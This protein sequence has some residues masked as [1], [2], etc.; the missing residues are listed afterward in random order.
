VARP[1]FSSRKSIFDP[2][3][4]PLTVEGAA[5]SLIGTSAFQ[6]LW[7]IRQTGF[8]HLV[9]PG[10]NH[11]RLEHSLGTYHVARQMGDRL[12]FDRAQA[13][14]VAAGA[15]LHDLGHGPFSHTLDGPMVEALGFGHE[16]LSR[17]WIEQGGPEESRWREEGRGAI[18]SVLESRG[19]SPRRTADLVDPAESAPATLAGEILHGAIDA[20]RLDYL[21]RD[22]HYTGV[23][24]GAI[25]ATRLLDTVEADGRRLVF[26]EKGRS[27][28]EGFLVGRSLMYASVY[29]H[30][31][32]RAG[33]VMA[34]A[35][36]ERLPG[37]PESARSVFFGNDGELLAHLRAA[38]GLPERIT[39]ALETRNLYKRA[40]ALRDVP[41]RYR[42]SLERLI[43]RPSDRR[44]FEDRVAERLELAPG[45]V[46]VDLAGLKPRLSP[47]H[48]W[49]NVGIREEHRVLFP[50]RSPSLWSRLAVRPP[51][52][53]PVAVYVEPSARATATRRL[54]RLLGRAL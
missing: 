33:E 52:P 29:Y 37:F 39:R 1:R 5:L 18:P 45:E 7:G 20:D 16:R 32:V 54:P 10:A 8:A 30:K 43:G 53:W 42:R 14:R 17:I 49:E 23:A 11:T 25:D 41:N 36:V 31:T 46:L 50:F 51:S 26:A 38:G 44:A 3:H 22:A 2:V 34:Q 47:G 48:D 35:A 4:G 6:R 24:H 19:I 12:G 15:L 21:Q 28:V 27:A 40:L 9:F 13:D